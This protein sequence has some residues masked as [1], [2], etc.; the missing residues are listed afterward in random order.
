MAQLSQ[1]IRPRIIVAVLFTVLVA[2][3]TAGPRPAAWPAIVHTCLGTCLVVAGAVVLNQWQERHSDRK[4]ARTATRPL[5]AGR[6]SGPLA[7]CIGLGVSAAGFGYLFFLAGRPVAAAAAFGWLVYVWIYTPLK[8]RTAWQTP[9]GALAGAMPAVIGATAAGATFSTLAL[10]QVGI[11]FLW[12][13]PHTMAIGWLYRRQFAA[14]KLPLAT[15]VDPSGRLAAAVAVLG[16]AALLAV[17]L[18]PAIVGP[19]SWG[20]AVAA[21][22]LGGGYLAGAVKFS[23]ARSDT[24][25]RLLLRA[26]LVY[27]PAMF[28]VLLIAVRW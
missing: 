12:Q 26:S 25:A 15:V 20:Y 4:M 10:V 23:L 19:L 18:M 14:A 24:T 9:V 28:A 2:A 13:L 16:A 1:L 11:L 6:L 17:S 3:W 7:V 27:L 5:P 21:V 8:P 22:F